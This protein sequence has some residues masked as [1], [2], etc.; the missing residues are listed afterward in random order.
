[1]PVTPK[2]I[3]NCLD[4]KK[5]VFSILT[6]E[7]RELLKKHHHCVKYNAHEIIFR[8]GDMPNAL[9]CLSDGKVKTF[10][11]GV[12]G[13]EQIVRLAKP[14]GFIGY[15]ALFAGERYLA[16]AVTIE[17][18]SV[19]FIEKDALLEVVKNNSVFAM[20]IISS[21]ARELGVSNSRVV[22]LTQ[23]HVRGRL[24]EALLFLKD[25]YGF[26]EDGFTLKA[27]LS[28]EDLAGLSN[29][30]TSN[31][32]RTLSQFNQEKLIE[33]KRR[34]IKILQLKKIE[35]ISELG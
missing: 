4:N 14:V 16:T 24:A 8:E 10:K 18:C 13:R 30:T 35:Q 33:I 34:K 32:I 19:C 3:C 29:M 26:E 27:Y 23:K 22:T 12:G 1:M 11:E 7:E 15:R 20:A 2:P 28:R 6:E 9:I 5:S 31:A 21:L 17:P 25:T